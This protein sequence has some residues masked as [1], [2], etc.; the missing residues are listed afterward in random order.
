[1]KTY[2]IKENKFTFNGVNCYDMP[3]M[4]KS[5][6]EFLLGEFPDA[7]FLSE[8][9]FDLK[10]FDCTNGAL[11]IR[12]SYPTFERKTADR[13]LKYFASHTFSSVKFKAGL[14][15]G[16]SKNSES[17]TIDVE[18]GSQLDSLSSYAAVL[19][20]VRKNIISSHL[21]N[22][23][24]IENPASTFISATT[25]I[26]AGAVIKHDVEITGNSVIK[27]GAVIN[28]YTNIKDGVIGSNSTVTSSTV[29]S[30][31]VGSGTTVGP[32]AYL[33]P[34]A[35]IGDNCRIGDF[36]EIKN[37]VIGNGTK[38]SHLSYV[39]D[40]TVG[41]RVNVGCGVVFVN[42]DGRHKHKSVIG[43]ECF[44]GSNCNLIAPVTMADNSFLAAG[45]TL[46]KDLNTGDFCI[47]RERETVKENRAL[48]YFGT[49]KEEK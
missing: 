16:K 3:I 19:D 46:T 18:C 17:Q 39:G 7:A 20:E 8:E 14:V 48:N 26:E 41:E 2:I 27:S 25:V 35:V 42:Y 33:R 30:A 45:T 37:A 22:G 34:K 9:E 40:A 1:M 36:V 24:L 32:N 38:V 23:V 11:V 47:G 43:N 4:G 12:S 5:S 10:K 15:V 13:I 29:E 44:I 28:A 49:A 6:I 31:I 21:K